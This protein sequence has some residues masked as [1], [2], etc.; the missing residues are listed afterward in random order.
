MISARLDLFTGLFKLQR[1]TTHNTTAAALLPPVSQVERHPSEVFCL[2]LQ[3]CN[4]HPNFLTP[5][6]QSH[7][8]GGP[9]LLRHSLS[10]SLSYSLPSFIHFVV[11]P[12]FAPP[13][14]I[15]SNIHEHI[16]LIRQLKSSS[17]NESNN[18]RAR[19]SLS[20]KAKCMA[21]CFRLPRSQSAQRPIEP[22]PEF[23]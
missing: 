12:P 4:P 20:Q 14:A 17:N 15:Q 6:H 10:R 18:N 23:S 7:Y 5:S 22:Y 13:Q 11:R 16:R 1:C 21:H 9:S 8:V 3:Q 2:Q 19:L